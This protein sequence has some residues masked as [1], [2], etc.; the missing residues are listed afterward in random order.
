MALKKRESRT[1]NAFMNCIKSGE[2]TTDY[3]VVLIEDVQKYGW[4]SD[5][6][7][8]EFYSWLDAYEWKLEIEERA[9]QASAQIVSVEYEETPEDASDDETPPETEGSE[10]NNSEQPA[11]TPE[12]ESGAPE[13]PQEDETADPVPQSEETD[14][15]DPQVNESEPEAEADGEGD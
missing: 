5:E 4:L 14:E 15:P 12:D 2:F 9:K 7:K 8:D 1:I 10:P 6:A 3:A 13:S 11:E